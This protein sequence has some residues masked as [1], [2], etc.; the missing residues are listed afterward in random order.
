M[1]EIK[2]INDEQVMQTVEE[3]LA[4]YEEDYKQMASEDAGGR[5]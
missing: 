2:T 1:T 4:E 3:L 5:D